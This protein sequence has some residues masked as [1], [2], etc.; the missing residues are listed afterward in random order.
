MEKATDVGCSV[1]RVLAAAIAL[2]FVLCSPA[3]AQPDS[4]AARN[5]GS[6]K[7]VDRAYRSSELVELIRLDSTI[8][9]DIRYASANNFM[10]RP[11]YAQARAFLQRP[12]AA[13]LVRAH[14]ALRSR[15]LGLMVFDGYRPWAVTK[16]F[17]DETPPSKR[18]FVANPQKGS[19]HNRGCAVDL[20]LFDLK[21][22]REIAM[23]SPYDDFTEKASS[24]Y[25]GGTDEERRMRGLLRSVMEAEGFSVEPVEWWH[26]DYRQWRDYGILDIPFEKLN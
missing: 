26:F 16:K 4:G 17:W 23:P 13:A 11:L 6:K 7:Q 10:K 18:Q 12:A 20:T 24:T 22:G 15:G 14:R 8:R 1:A 19:K 3:P 2:S 21:T 5:F 9:L 25:A